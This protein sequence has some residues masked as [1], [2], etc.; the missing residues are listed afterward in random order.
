MRPRPQELEHLNLAVNNITAVEGLG[1]CESLRKVDL[2]LNFV[3][4]GGLP[5]LACLRS[6]HLLE[7][8]HL[9]GNP[10]A[11]WHGYRAYVAATLPQL[12]RLDGDE[13]GD[14]ERR[15]ALGALSQL[16]AQ[17]AQEHGAD[18]DQGAQTGDSDGA[19]LDGAEG[20]GA[21][22]KLQSW[23]PA[24]RVRDHRED[25]A[26]A[27]AA[28]QAK[29]AAADRLLAGDDAARRRRPL[30]EALPPLPPDGGELRQCNEGGLE[31]SLEE[32]EGEGAV[33][34]SVALP[35]HL[36]VLTQVQVDVQPAAVRLLAEGQLLQLRLPAEVSPGRAAARR[37]TCTGRLVITMP[38]DRGEILC[39]AAPAGPR[40]A[41]RR[42]GGASGRHG[43]GSG[44]PR[45]A[46]AAAVSAAPALE[47]GQATRGDDLPPVA[48]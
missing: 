2:T 29:R 22:E 13:V 24:T 28:E 4:P 8:L 15:A 36:C 38:L 47:V 42:Q 20:A 14:E 11:T 17:L 31:F 41:G 46:A 12:R 37:S 23:C 30:R 19:G 32:D 1:R 6:C 3:P 16:R 25:A 48:A 5:S 18:A 34:L 35:R 10:C 43:V 45:A 26:A 39:G 21:E 33:V 9:V 40:P 7:E 27:A 44:G